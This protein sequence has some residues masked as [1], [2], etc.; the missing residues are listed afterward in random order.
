MYK[1]LDTIDIT[2]YWKNSAFCKYNIKRLL[3]QLENIL[4]ESQK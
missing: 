3:I 1:H 2:S 4:S